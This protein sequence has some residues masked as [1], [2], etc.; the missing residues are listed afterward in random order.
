MF[1]KNV[2]IYLQG[3]ECYDTETFT[4]PQERKI[5]FNLGYVWLYLKI[6]CEI[7]GYVGGE[8]EDSLLDI[9]AV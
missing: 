2:G 8:S 9:E 6:I 7:S 1:L 4:Q 5:P 3:K